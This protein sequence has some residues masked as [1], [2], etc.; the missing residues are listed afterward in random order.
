VPS[1][2]QSPKAY[3]TA[4]VAVTVNGRQPSAAVLTQLEGIR[5]AWIDYW[6]KVTG[7]VSTMR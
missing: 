4:M 5:T 1:F 3:T 6:S 2:E 7:W